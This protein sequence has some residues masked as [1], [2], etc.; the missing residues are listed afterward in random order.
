LDHEAA[1]KLPAG[2]SNG[3]R[4]HVN[5]TDAYLDS[6]R[7]IRLRRRSG[8]RQRNIGPVRWSETW[9][10]KHCS[11]WFVVRE[12]HC[13]AGLVNNNLRGEAVGWLVWFRPAN[14]PVVGW[15]IMFC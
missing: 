10:K 7:I 2:S 4:E 5:I 3:S 12:K 15:I 9:L 1:T 11:G 6:R 13:S 8:G 14:S